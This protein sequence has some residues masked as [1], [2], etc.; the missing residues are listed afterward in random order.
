MSDE[1]AELK[2][3][4]LDALIKAL[5]TKPPQARVGIL[6]TKTNRSSKSSKETATNATI[7]AAH[8]FGTSKLPERSFLRIPISDHLQS[9]MENS[10][11]LDKETLDAVIKEK[12]II[13]WMT[14]VAILAERIVLDAFDSGG[15]GKWKPSNMENKKVQQTLVE[16]RQLERSITHEVKP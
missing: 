1:A 2:T 9:Y 15:F 7:G 5:K 3:P 11:A 10:G 13:P 4:G 8:E 16:T 14:K 6:G 12:T